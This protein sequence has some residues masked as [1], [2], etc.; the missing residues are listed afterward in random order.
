[1]P[2]VLIKKV[3]CGNE[4]KSIDPKNFTAEVVMSDETLD[5]YNEVIEV[6]G[7]KDTIKQFMK[8]PVLLSSHRYS[9]DLRAQIGEWKDVRIEGKKLVGIP[10]YY[11]GEGNP[12]AD[13][14]WK[15]VEKK[16]AAYSVGIIPV[17]VETMD[18]D[19]WQKLKDEGKRVARRRYLEQELIETSHVLIPANPAALQRSIE[20]EDEIEKDVATFYFTNLDSIKEF[21]NIEIIESDVAEKFLIKD[22][23]VD[24]KVESATTDKKIEE[25]TDKGPVNKG[26]D[27][28]V[29]YLDS[30]MLKITLLQ[31]SSETNKSELITDITEKI[32]ALMLRQLVD[33]DLKLSTLVETLTTLFNV[34]NII[35]NQSYIDGILEKDG[36]TEEPIVSSL[37]G[38]DLKSL[39]S[40]LQGVTDSLHKFMDKK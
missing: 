7:Y 22:P 26:E 40:S 9:G 5:R 32:S 23:E 12:E 1:M 14:A 13:W 16:I 37:K 34:K 24:M 11:V 36:T 15:L 10:K 18:Y 39:M 31:N 2:N 20:G 25:P 29:K 3:F 6:G 17:K 33:I 8:H 27:I 19:K 35:P 28:V 4:I 21:G 38:E 30:I